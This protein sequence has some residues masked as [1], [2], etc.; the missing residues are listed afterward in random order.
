MKNQVLSIEQM[1]TL[2]DMGIDTSKATCYWVNHIDP[3][4]G[5]SLFTRKP[6]NGGFTYI[7]TF[8]LQDCMEMLPN[9]IEWK[10]KTYWFSVFINA[11]GNKMLGYRDSELWALECY[12]FS[13]NGAFNMLKWCKENNF[14]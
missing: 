12:S 7:P 14:I 1:K 8:T 2:I 13:I 5:W 10:G 11:M 3:N 4:M 9:T 6:D